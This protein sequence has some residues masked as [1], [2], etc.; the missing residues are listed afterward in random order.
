VKDRDK[1][2]SQLAA[3][4]I[5]CGIHYPIPLHLQKAYESLA[6]P[7]GRLPVAEKCASEFVSLPM[8]PELKKEQIEYVSEIL[9]SLVPPG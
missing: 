4:E 1:I 2:I 8:Y 9:Q 7:T 3:R 5:F 6:I